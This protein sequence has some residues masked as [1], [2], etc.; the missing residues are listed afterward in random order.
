[1]KVSRVKYV[2]GRIDLLAHVFDAE[3]CGVGHGST[4][5]GEPVI[6]GS[7]HGGEDGGRRE[8]DG[9]YSPWTMARRVAAT[10]V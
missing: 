5:S 8:R 1:M 2:L 4:S 7:W 9:N 6:L 10:D 3:V